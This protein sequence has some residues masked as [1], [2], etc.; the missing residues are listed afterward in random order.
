MDLVE[1]FTSLS[2]EI[3]SLKDRLLHLKAGTHW[4]TNGEWKESVIRQILRRNLPDT[5]E[6]GRGFVVTGSRA[7]R[8]VDVLI[9]D[10]TKPV[11]FRDGDLAFVTPDAVL[12]IIEVKSR[13]TSHGFK[14]AV[15]K[16]AAN[17]ELV[18][19][20]PRSGR[21]ICPPNTWAFAA[22]FIF[23]PD[24]ANG[25]ALLNILADV[26]KL[27]ERRIDFASIG[28]SVFLKYWEL[29]PARYWHATHEDQDR[30]YPAW[31]SYQ[32]PS[33]APGYFVHNAV[34]AISPESV[35]KNSEVW[36]PRGGKEL[37]RDGYIKAAW[38]QEG[39]RIDET[40]RGGDPKKR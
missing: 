15:R 5:V 8:Q 31:H 22:L 18:R 40:T 1:Y 33:R 20:P 35:F 11:V 6:V 34:D 17:I 12:G 4:L 14:E 37:Y 39:P 26:I 10:A 38:P 36:W 2:R 25:Q 27:P 19:L 23:E 3:D 7:T 29:N 32:L 24:N 16:L 9:R 30:V 13:F 21:S 28:N